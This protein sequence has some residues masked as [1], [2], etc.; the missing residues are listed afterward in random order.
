MI[1]RL[2][3]VPLAC[4]ALAA[5]PASA[6]RAQARTADFHWEGPVAAGGEVSIHNVNGN[7]KVTPSTT[8]RV[9]VAGVKHGSG[10]E[11]TAE[12]HQTSRGIVVCVVFQDADTRCD[13]DGYSSSSHRN[14]NRDDNW[15]DASMDLQVTVP[16][17]LTVSANSVSGDV[18]ITGAQG[19]VRGGSVSGDVRMMHLRAS[20]VEANSVSGDLDV[21]IDELT[22]RGD[23]S[24]HTVSGDVSLAVPRQFD[25][26][27]S[28]STVSGEIDS[29]YAM[30]LTNGRTSR[31][32]IQARIGSG[33]RRLELNTV[34]GDVKIRSNR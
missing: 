10:R 24:F 26:D 34:S 21:Q 32:S 20:S 31:R 7:V 11:V 12:V 29:D 8:G 22:G 28:M 16:A 23:L 18:D 5:L 6:L 3:C 33:G 15:N 9:E 27:L 4:V 19:D 13:E 2:L 17:N 30:T 14:R 25:V 1:T